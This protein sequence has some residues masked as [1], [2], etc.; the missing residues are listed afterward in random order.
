MQFHVE[1]PSRNPKISSYDPIHD[2]YHVFHDFNKLGIPVFSNKSTSHATSDKTAMCKM[3]VYWSSHYQLFIK[4][5]TLTVFIQCKF[6]LFTKSH[7]FIWSHLRYISKGFCIGGTKGTQEARIV[8]ES[9]VWQIIC[10]F[11]NGDEFRLRSEGVTINVYDACAQKLGGG[12]R[13]DFWYQ[14]CP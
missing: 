1:C 11:F 5:L 14:H 7:F 4:K 6:N 10:V 3:T 12:F 8:S 2:Q 13:T 9:K